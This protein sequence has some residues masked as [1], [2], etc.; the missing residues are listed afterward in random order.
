LINFNDI[1][2]ATAFG[3]HFLILAQ[4]DTKKTPVDLISETKKNF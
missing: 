3:K 1:K 2:L 4:Y